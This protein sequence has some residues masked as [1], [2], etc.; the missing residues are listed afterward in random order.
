M[1]CFLYVQHRV[2]LFLSD[3]F[4]AI[5]KHIRQLNTCNQQP[6]CGWILN[7]KTEF[8]CVL[9]RFL[10]CYTS[11]GVYCRVKVTSTHTL[12][13]MKLACVYFQTNLHR[14]HVI[15]YL[16]VIQQISSHKYE[17]IYS[18][19]SLKY[20]IANQCRFNRFIDRVRIM[21]TL[22]SPSVEIR[23]SIWTHPFYFHHVFRIYITIIGIQLTV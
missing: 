16:Y 3:R 4:A 12:Q 21:S 11:T 5:R 7:L 20:S 1:K 19:I 6:T 18:T 23:Q 10:T 8:V 15:E 13:Y 2:L 14:S 9:H 22:H 17:C